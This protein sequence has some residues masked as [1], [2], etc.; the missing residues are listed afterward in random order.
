FVIDD[1]VA[2]AKKGGFQLL[3]QPVGLDASGQPDPGTIE[4]K[5]KKL[6]ADGAE[7]LYLGPDTFIAFTHRQIT[8]TAAIT[9]GLP[10]FTANESAIQDGYALYGLH[11]PTENLARF[12]AYKAGQVLTQ[13]RKI[14]ET[15][16]ETLQRF[17]ST[18]NLCA[19]FALRVF[20]PPALFK[21]ADVIV[22]LTDAE[23]SQ[24]K[25]NRAPGSQPAK[26]CRLI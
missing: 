11:S 13:E 24:D 23:A 16:V 25:T 20:P 18:I 3:T 2:E 8:T 26:G 17:S 4:A 21:L 12:T 15:P 5:V 9:A 7:W 14:S 6:K 1:L 19:A 22:P 10:A